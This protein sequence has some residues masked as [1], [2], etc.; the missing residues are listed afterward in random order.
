MPEEPKL[1]TDIPLKHA[2]KC[3]WKVWS[4]GSK[5]VEIQACGRESIED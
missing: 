5:T 4:K 2:P 1:S 3:F